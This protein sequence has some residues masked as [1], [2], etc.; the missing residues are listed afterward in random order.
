[1]AR[2][3]DWLDTLSSA[4]VFNGSVLIAK[5]GR[6]LLEGH[7]G[8]ADTEGQVP[9]GESASFSL[10]SVSKPFTGLAI[11]LLVHRA[12][13]GLD[14]VLARHIPE[15]A[16]YPGVTVRHL[17]HHTSGLPDH[18]WLADRYWDPG[19]TLTTA[20][21]I[22]LF[23]THR[24]PA[25]FAPGDRFE[26]SNTGYVL[27]SEI[28]ARAS[29]R[30]FVD[31]MAE[32]IFAPLGM[33]DSAAYNL[34]CPVCTLQCRA[35]GMRRRF[36]CFGR[37]VASDM[38]YLDGVFGDGGIHASAR[39]LLRWDAALREGTL[40]PTDAYEQAYTS[41]RLNN[42]TAIDYGFGWEIRPRHVVEHLGEW[43]GFATCCA[44]T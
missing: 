10:A 19:V 44:G 43:E 5:E 6:I 3:R 22:G 21:M 9:L 32:E 29:G 40:I 24:P 34:T 30:P 15:L 33:N 7:C 35:T 26:Y 17:L 4:G 13:L 39:D 31:F 38:N 41:G 18:M 27:L 12:R 42:G 8:F 1:M 37:R 2:V 23:V 16:D 36:G 11:M 25:R 20:D 28:I 14:D